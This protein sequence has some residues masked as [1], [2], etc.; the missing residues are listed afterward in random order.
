MKEL[1]TGVLNNMGVFNLIVTGQKEDKVCLSIHGREQWVAAGD[2]FNILND[3]WRV[4]EVRPVG[5]VEGF[6]L[7]PNK[8]VAVISQS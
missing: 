5:K 1:I 7:E 4:D 3:V 8:V 6:T 2:S